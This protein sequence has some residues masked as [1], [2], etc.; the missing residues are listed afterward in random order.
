MGQDKRGSLH[1]PLLGLGFTSGT[2]MAAAEAR[3]TLQAVLWY[4]C[5]AEKISG[6]L[7]DTGYLE[8]LRTVKDGRQST[9]EPHLVLKALT[10]FTLSLPSLLLTLLALLEY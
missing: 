6:A 5:T 2:D 8:A 10:D 1:D 7:K 3:G 4:T 9:D